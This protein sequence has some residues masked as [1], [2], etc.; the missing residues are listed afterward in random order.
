MHSAQNYEIILSDWLRDH[1]GI[2]LKVARSFAAE[3]TL[4][5]ELF[6]EMIFQL[7][8]SLPGFQGQA[9][10][11]TWIYR[12]CF[13]TALTWKRTEQK[14]RYLTTPLDEFSELHCPDP[15]PG[16]L[17]EK[18]ETLAALYT[19]VRELKPTERSLV[20]LLL[21]GLSYRDIAEISGLSENHVG[22]AL[23]RA[24]KKLGEMMEGVRHEL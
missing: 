9:K 2:L 15:Q 12:V 3:P 10:A 11:S 6:Q 22:V 1:R 16:E 13:N 24:R 20:I 23:T 21:D 18:R 4:Q 8:R 5:S 14:R 19:A 17:Q 7:W